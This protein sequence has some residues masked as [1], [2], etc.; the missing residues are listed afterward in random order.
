MTTP[1]RPTAAD[2]RYWHGGVPGLR[3]GDE[4]L[5]P[6]IT[7]NKI[8]LT[9]R[10]VPSTVDADHARHDRV[11]LT[12]NRAAARAFAACYPN[13]ALYIAEPI[14]ATEPDPDA[15]TVSIRCERARVVSVYDPCVLW[16]ERGHRWLRALE[17]AK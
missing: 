7:G 10:Y 11:Y 16:S 13:G 15:P 14:G 6:T 5:P 9:A 8:A 17:G 12:T 2:V 3:P 1:N 4:L